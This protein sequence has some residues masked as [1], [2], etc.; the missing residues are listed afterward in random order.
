MI[1]EA[2]N[3]VEVTVG[4]WGTHKNISVDKCCGGYFICIPNLNL[5]CGLT[6]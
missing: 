3:V 4:A 6:I 1:R 5:E 2:P